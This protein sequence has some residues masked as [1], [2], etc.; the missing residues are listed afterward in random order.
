MIHQALHYGRRKPKNAPAIHLRSIL[1]TTQVP[2]HPAM[3]DYLQRLVAWL[4]LGNNLAG[5][6]VAVT[7]ANVRR[8][9]T[10]VLTGHESYPTL[11]QVW[12]FYKTQ[13]PNFDPNGDPNVNGPG[14]QADGGMDIQT[15]LEYLVKVGGPDGVKA[16]AFAKVDHTNRDEVQAA[17]AIFGYVWVGINVTAA[18]E[19][20]FPNQPWDYVPGSPDEGG[21]SIITGGYLGKPNADMTFITWAQEQYFTDSFWANQVEEAWVAIWPE[22]LGTASF[23]AGVDG[24]A[25]AAAY[26]ELT[27]RPFPAP[28]PAPT[29]TPSPSPTPTPDSGLTINITD[30]VI[31]ERLEHVSRGSNVDTWATHHFHSYFRI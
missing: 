21:H 7:W 13:N 3:V 1:R 15:A 16:V 11:A 5:D 12:Q 30:S 8:L 26:Q 6:C 17:I 9:V 23:E 27:G 4:M 31:V 2:V 18:N 19:Q 29:P 28:T 20:Q 24:E 25:L 10:Y 22:H 14:S